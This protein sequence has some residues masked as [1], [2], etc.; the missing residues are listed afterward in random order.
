MSDE[1]W[2]KELSSDTTYSGID[3]RREYGKMTRWC[4]TN[5][6]RPTKR[7]FVNWLNKAEP[8]LGNGSTPVYGKRYLP[9]VREVSEE[10]LTAYRKIIAEEKAKLKAQLQR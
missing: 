7:R 4:S 10:E 8:T 1:D 2:I 5:G 6:K 3:V 9:P